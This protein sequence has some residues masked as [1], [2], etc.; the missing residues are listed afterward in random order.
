MPASD[1]DLGRKVTLRQLKIF[2]S[3]ARHGSVTRAAEELYLT[4]PTAS[5]QVK[6]LSDA[7]GMPL[8]EQ[9]GRQLH[10]TEIGRDLYETCQEIF[11][12]LERLEMRV[13]DMEGLKRGTLKLAV[14]TTAKYFAPRVLGH[15]KQRYS[16]IQVSLKVSNRERIL[17]RLAANED[18]IYIMGQKPAEDFEVEAV[19]IAPNPLVVMASSAHPLAEQARIPLERIAEEPYIAREEGSGIRESARQLFASHGLQ[20]N[21]IMELSSNEAIKHAVAGGL[22]VSVLSLHSLTL[23]GSEGPVIVLDVEGFPIARYWYAVYP[24]GKKLSVVA[25]SFLEF[26][27]EEGGR[28]AEHMERMMQAL[29]TSHSISR[30]E[31]LDRDP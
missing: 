14:V 29:P 20:P 24:K 25:Q 13:A 6:K 30:P 21:I 27:V 3:L 2:E 7:V 22:G 9:I 17:E 28:A 18:D 10:L 8:F 26:M 1:K 12:S 11:G 23:E 16:G 31:P 5:M 4:Q 15:F 19:P